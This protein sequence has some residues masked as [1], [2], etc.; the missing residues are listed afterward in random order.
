MRNEFLDYYAKELSF[1][2]KLG[3]EFSKKHPD[4]AFNIGIKE[5]EI[6]DPHVSRLVESFAFLTAKI[7]KRMDEDFDS[8][9]DSLLG[10]LTP[11]Y[12]API[13][14]F[15]I[16]KIKVDSDLEKS[17]LFPKESILDV[18][19]QDNI[20][21][22]LTTCYDMVLWPLEISSVKME[23]TP[24][25]KL[26]SKLPPNQ[27]KLQ[28]DISL[29]NEEISICNLQDLDSLTFYINLNQSESFKLYEL[30]F[31]HSAGIVLENDF[32]DDLI[33][34][35]N[36]LLEVGF[37]LEESLLPINEKSL[38]SYQLIRDLF[39]FPKK[40]LFF[41]IKNLSKIANL[42]EK[43][44]T[45]HLLFD[46]YIDELDRE[47]FLDSIQLNCTPVKNLFSVQFD[48]FLL[49]RSQS[50]IH[51]IADS[52]NHPF[53]EIHSVTEAKASCDLDEIINFSPIYKPSSYD[54]RNQRDYNF[55]QKR[56]PAN[57]V[58]EGTTS[59]TESFLTLTD[60]EGKL[61]DGKEWVLE[62]QGLCSNRNYFEL[63]SYL[64]KSQ[65]QIQLEE[66]V[67]AVKEVTCLTHFS[68]PIWPEFDQNAKWGLISHLTLESL[69][70]E[71]GI[72][73]LKRI[74]FL[75]DPI[76]S[77]ANLDL[78]HNL[79]SLNSQTITKK[80]VL[81]KYATVATGTKMELLTKETAFSGG[82]GFLLGTII[83]QL[84]KEQAAVNTF[85]DFELKSEKERRVW[86]TWL[87]TLGSHT[88]I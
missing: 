61:F 37:S 81:G 7:H 31:N 88:V 35:K 85:V 2:K 16:V 86:R 28:I 17:Q 58:L 82:P 42:T 21:P 19:N 79:I 59:G 60:N 12:L 38:Y 75:Y 49:D 72:S 13:P 71:K 14:S 68:K 69:A 76:K 36:S 40:F 80:V 73:H 64:D 32:G 70:T 33:I 39:V 50:E 57:S 56:V 10:I 45:I 53:T 6:E 23:K 78:I 1:I 87:D 20:T 26:R 46:H 5:N 62:T 3:S 51:L 4:I 41:K 44:F 77:S 34:D 43:K 65:F 47:I 9:V 66:E 48:P 25:T 11:D 83:S 30:I 29:L 15:S 52:S 54:P 24:Y 55:S 74:L 8:L 63:F 27:C 18:V 84:L 22:K 67:S